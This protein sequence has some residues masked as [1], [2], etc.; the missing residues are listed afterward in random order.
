MTTKK[1]LEVCI[2][3]CLLISGAGL[4]YYG[5]TL[6]T[7]DGLHAFE[8]VGS[9]VLAT[10]GLFLA[11][12]AFIYFLY[13]HSEKRKKAMMKHPN[14]TFYTFITIG[15]V[16]FIVGFIGDDVMLL[17][18]HSPSPKDI[19]SAFC[20][21]AFLIA[22][23]QF[24]ST[25]RKQNE[26][27]NVKEKKETNQSSKKYLKCPKQNENE[28]EKQFSRTNRQ[29]CI[30]LVLLIS[31]AGLLYYGNT[32]PTYDGLHALELFGC[33]VLATVSFFLAFVTS[34]YFLY[35]HS[36]KRKKAMN[37][38]PNVIFN[39]PNVIFNIF[40]TIGLAFTIGVIIGDGVM[41]SQ[42]Y[43]PSPKN[44]LPAVCGLAFSIGIFKFAKIV[45]Q[46]LML[47]NK[48]DILKNNCETTN[49]SGESS[50]NNIK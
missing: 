35:E 25:F 5:N 43:S 12:V 44:I 16:V 37:Q 26:N 39:N 18:G 2:P 3:L 30:S 19:L 24:L 32:L 28:E 34:I 15:I 7:Y 14:F 50:I 20:G 23:T 21:F 8:L 45:D 40:K 33:D 22:T 31:G 47:N 46:K 48:Q 11:L 38:H 27:K 6:P 9:D 49:L 13:E 42:G 29:G 10:V 41:F 4:L 1:N 36:G 17:Q